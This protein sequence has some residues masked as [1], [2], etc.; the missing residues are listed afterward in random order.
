MC[1]FIQSVPGRPLGG[2][3]VGAA[4]SHV[5]GCG[6]QA[7]RCAAAPAEVIWTALGRKS[8]RRCEADNGGPTGQGEDLD[9]HPEGFE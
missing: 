1:S 5:M 6:F 2:G 9:Y 7:G 8:E 4:L 3:E